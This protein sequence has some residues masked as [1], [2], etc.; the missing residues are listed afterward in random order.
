MGRLKGSK[1]KSNIDIP[2]IKD[3]DFSSDNIPDCPDISLHRKPVHDSLYCQN[4]RHSLRQPPAK[5][6]YPMQ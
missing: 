1:N 3:V 5:W 6:E 4:N 2:D